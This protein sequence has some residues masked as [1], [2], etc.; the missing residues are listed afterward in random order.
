MATSL[1]YDYVDRPIITYRILSKISNFYH[2]QFLWAIIYCS[3][4]YKI[5]HT[6]PD[7]GDL[8]NVG[9]QN[10]QRA[11][12]YTLDVAIQLF[13]D[14][15]SLFLSAIIVVDRSLEHRNINNE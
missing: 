2:L 11:T 8:S 13:C 4:F 7:A 1:L 5:I 6:G 14:F 15:Y 12:C 3:T 9:N 10:Q